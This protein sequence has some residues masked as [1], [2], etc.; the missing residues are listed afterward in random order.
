MKKF[1]VLLILL[2]MIAP[3]CFAMTFSQPVKIGG[4]GF[5]IQSPYHGFI[6]N[7]AS[8]NNGTY[9]IEKPNSINGIKED[10]KTYIKG[11][12]CFGNGDNALYCD[13]NFNATDHNNAIKFG[14]NDNYIIFTESLYKTIYRIDT[15]EGLTIY[16]IVSISGVEQINIIGRQKDG[17]WVSYIDSEILTNK[18][19]GG[20][21]A[22][23]SSD[24]VHYSLLQVK[25]D[26]I[27]IP[28]KY[29][30]H[31]VVTEGEFRFKWDDNAQW[32]GVEQVVY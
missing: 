17:K 29:Q 4:I 14:G 12:A 24:G 27:I 26:T 1:F 16:S 8:Y 18:Y 10:F 13:Y 21:Q 22:Y 2:L 5:P 23:K 32:F 6:V 15:D 20:K 31:K 25:N 28:Y 30:L 9:Y 11:I 3:N 7:G 19:F